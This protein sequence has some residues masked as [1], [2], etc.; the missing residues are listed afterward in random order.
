MCS[1]S[2][3]GWIELARRRLGYRLPRLG[4]RVPRLLSNR[5]P[6]PHLTELHPGLR[7]PVVLTRDV[8]L[9]TWWQGERYEAP[10]VPTLLRWLATADS[11]FDIG[12][13]YGWYSYLALARHSNVAVTAFEPNTD[14]VNRMTAVKTSQGLDRFHIEPLALGDMETESE[15][16]MGTEP[17][18]ATLGK[19]PDLSAS[20]VVRV[21][22]FDGWRTRR[23]IDTPPGPKWVAKIDAE[24]Y[25][26]KILKGMSESLSQRAFI[27]LVVELNEFTLNF[28]GTSRNEV[29]D[30]LAGHGYE[31][32]ATE[33][34]AS[35][36]NGF[37]VPAS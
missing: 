36:E 2:L 37:F 5:L 19:H 26:L 7:V 29:V 12:A 18:H 16:R 33:R 4:P 31:Q 32:L 6:N 17:A 27:G 21:E 24:G 3:A 9:A 11:F 22:T 34:G 14:L 20:T 10:T 35:I 8:E 28:C 15:L 30:E 23:G 25:E 1:E 13:N